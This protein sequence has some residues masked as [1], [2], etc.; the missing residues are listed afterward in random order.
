M[1]TQNK[2]AAF[3]SLRLG[4]GWILW[5]VVLLLGFGWGAYNLI[6]QQWVHGLEVTGLNVSIYWGL[7]IV[8]FV[9]LI[10]VSAGGIIVGGLAYAVGIERFRPVAR[11]AELMAISC[12][13]LA[14]LFIFVSIG[15]P[16]RFYFLFL[17]GRLGSPLIWDVIIIFLYLALALA[18]GYFGTRADLVRCMNALPGRRWL[19]RLLVLGYTDLSPR[20]L[21]RD[22]KIL[23]VLAITSVPAAVL[24]HSITAWILGVV[25]AR[26]TWHTSL[27]GPLF[28]V[29]AVVS[30]LALLILS[31]LAARFIL[32]LRVKRETIV[33]LGKLLAF[34]IPVLGYF[35]FAEL[36]TVTFGKE[37]AHMNI[38]NEMIWGHFAP[39]FWSNLAG[40]LIL[41][42][43]LLAVPSGVARG[44]AFARAGV[45]ALAA[46]MLAVMLALWPWGGGSAQTLLP[47]WLPGLGVLSRPV[48][49]LTFLI[50]L[51]LVLTFIVPT[52]S[53]FVRVG[54]AAALVVVGVFLERANIVILPQLRRLLFPFYP[55]GSY[56]P[57]TEELSIIVGIYALGALFFAVCSKI[58]PLVEIEEEG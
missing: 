34:S 10:G 56:M 21:D 8:N 12:L 25:K 30:G 46:V 57:T 53:D 13:I 37:P 5:V 36:L 45:T 33:D 54:T 32:G 28:V 47:T 18:L 27:I 1:D 26:V 35:L 14:T 49:L 22:R 19:Y 7:Y 38:F 2:M 15:A 58:I 44:W 40:G 23:R 4:W 17:Y 41:P 6:F 11:I 3:D 52:T 39:F 51:I 24:L 50:L 55:P 16:D 31:A 20:A 29:S 48:L 9:F 42:L 43:F